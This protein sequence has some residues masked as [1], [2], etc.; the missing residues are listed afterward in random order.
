MTLL[1]DAEQVSEA[2]DVDVVHALPVDRRGA[3]ATNL[4][5]DDRFLRRSQLA[6]SSA[7]LAELLWRRVGSDGATG[8]RPAPVVDLAEAEIE[9]GHA[10]AK[11][12][13]EDLTRTPR[14]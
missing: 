4:G 6:R 14:R 8:A 1:I 3:S 9:V 13:A 10:E 12:A 5:G 7:K 11:G 2:L